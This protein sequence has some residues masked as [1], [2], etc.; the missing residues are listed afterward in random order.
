MQQEKET[1]LGDGRRGRLRVF[2]GFAAGVGKTYGM[3][4][5][6]HELLLMG[7]N[8]V[9]G[10]IEPHDR[11]DT[12]RLLEG[13]PQIPP[14][15]IS[16]K[17]IILTEPD[18]DRI[19]QQKPEIVLIDEL[20]HTNAKDSR[21][22]K[23]YQD[24]DEL[25]N[26]GIDV[27]TTVNVQHIESLN[28][29]VEEVTGIEVKET[30]PDTFL[31]QATIKVIDVEPDE[32]IERLEQGK[33][34]AN[35]NAKRALQNFFIP[36]KLDQLRGL[37]IQRASDHINRISGKTI[38]IQS[39]LLTVVNDAFPKMTE[40][41]IRWTARLAQGLGA[42]WTVI[43]VRTQ[44]NT[45]TNIP[46]AEKLGAEV[47]SIEEDDSFETIVE[48]AKMTGVTDI[49]MGKNLRQPWYEKIFVEAFDDRLLKR[50]ND[51][52]LH[53]IPFKEEKQSL[54]FRTRKVIEGGGKDLAIAVG[55]VFLAT[56]VTE[57]MQY[58][59]VG[60]QNLMLVY[61]FFILLV[62]RTTSGYFWSAL[63]S[64]L[65]VLSFNWFFVEPLYSLTVYKQGYPITL[66][67]MLVVALM[68]SNL[69]VRLKKQA[70]NSM[71]KEHQMEI[72]YELNKQYVLAESRKQIL[73][74]SATYLSRLLEREVIIF[75]RQAKVESVYCVTGHQSIL[76]TKE[77]AAVAFWTAK[78]Q[79]EAGNGTDTLIGAK[80]F[81]LPIVASGKT[82]AVLG[83]ERNASLDLEN[84]QL[85]YL[86]LVLTQIAVILE[87]TELKNE[88]EQVELENEREKV[89]SNLLRA[90]SHDLRTPLTVISGIAETLGIGSD[91]KEETRQKLLTDIQEESQW[92][93]RM[94]ENLLSITRINMDTMK[95]DKTAEPVEEIIEAVYKH[96]KKV[97]PEGKIKIELPEDVIF[98]QA[99]PILIEQA[100]FNLVENAFRH[101][102]KEQPVKLTVR[103]QQEQ[104]VFEIENYGEIPLKQFQKIQTNLSST[105]E[106][107][108]DSKNGL[109]IGLSIV[110]T[111]IHA[112]N[113]KMEMTVG[114]GKTMVR[115]YLK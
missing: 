98:I 30:V 79:K 27:F 28:D 20:A 47:V 38:G 13:L 114:N 19:I 41:C 113:G 40:K 102:A 53:L 78:N 17:Q 89:R 110:K 65:S 74:I 49:I 96:L 66:L 91:L 101:G 67:I 1:S 3:L 37:A 62:A 82:L 31:Q 45:S 48:F 24:V 105:N 86:K 68:I 107:P 85:N 57:L 12:N 84:G 94:V 80:G 100:L 111:I 75:D 56:I 92:L 112:H 9:V 60:D 54:F 21:N 50:L 63:A 69:M 72:L 42:E 11:P 99:D 61:I 109:G 77:E 71:E 115:I 46:L 106:V 76:N 59:H 97:Y 44:E 18:I 93:I 36:H 95:V 88:K 103:L 25:L 90:V 29:I 8:V 16:Y 64:I 4:A 14:K 104:T 34:Y 70:D 52:E 5:E 6:A 33:I 51:T 10:Y 39:K 58:I 22:R 43:Q 83:I 2:F 7:K 87:Q 32:L 81:Y 23:R 15:K 35:E 108:V 26:A 73:D 55:G